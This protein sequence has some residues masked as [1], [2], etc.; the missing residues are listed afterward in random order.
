MPVVFCEIE[1]PPVRIREGETH[2]FACP[3]E[4]AD[5]LLPLLNE[6]ERERACRFRVERMR[7]QFIVAR[8]RLRR[9]LG[10]YL[11]ESPS[12]IVLYYEENGKPRVDT[13]RGLQ[14][15]L[16]HT[17]GLAVFAF[18]CSLVGIDVERI[19]SIPDADH[20][21]SRFFSKRFL[22]CLDSKGSGAKSDR[23]RR[24]VAGHLRGLVRGKRVCNDPLS[25]RR[26]GRR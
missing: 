17:E 16:S 5:S 10:H 19:R 22:A 3:I 15:N 9:L 23:A 7:Q 21:V 20:L 13:S 25:G 12:E 2:V 6:Q 24:V 11:A 8:G 1:S 18:G 26:R 14:F 4:G